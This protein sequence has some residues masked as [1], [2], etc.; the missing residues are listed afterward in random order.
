MQ[1]SAALFMR[2]TAVLACTWRDH[3]I[4][5]TQYLNIATE[6]LHS[7]TTETGALKFKK[8]SEVTFQAQTPDENGIFQLY[9]KVAADPKQYADARYAT[10]KTESKN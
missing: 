3:G 7:C 9:D 5:Y 4:S 10:T 8:F 6:A 1:R 2:P